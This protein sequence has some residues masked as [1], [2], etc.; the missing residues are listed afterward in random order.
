M[1]LRIYVAVEA[2]YEARELYE[3]AKERKAKN[4]SELHKLLTEAR[5]VERKLAADLREHVK[6]H[7]CIH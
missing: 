3:S 2:I 5:A 1:S 6:S 7:G 4:V